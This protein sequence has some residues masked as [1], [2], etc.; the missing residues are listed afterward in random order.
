MPGHSSPHETEWSL[1]LAACCDLPAETKAG[2]I[3]DLLASHIEWS[4]L[5]SLAENHGMMPL[6]AQALLSVEHEIP[7]EAI[8]SLKQ[9]YQANLHKAL[10][11]SREFVSIVE[12]L[13]QAGIEFLPYKGLA[14]AE[15][16]YGDIALRQTGD[17]DLLIHAADLKRVREAVAHLGYMPH[18]KLSAHEEEFYLRSGYEC[19]FDGPAGKNLLEVQWAIQPRFYAVDLGMEDLFH[20]AIKATVAGVDVKTLSPED[21]FV[22][23]ALHA[24]KHAWGKLIW[25]RD[26]SR[27]SRAPTLDWKSIA[28]RA[29]VLGIVRILWVTLLLA[30]KLFNSPVPASAREDLPE[31]AAAETL[32]EEIKSYV[33]SERIFDVESSTYFKLMIRLRERKSDRIRFLSRLAFTPGPGEWAVARFPKALFP[34]YRLIRITRLGSRIVSGRI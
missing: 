17:I 34:L 23:L 33:E 29:R 13:S 20:R 16:V 8:K 22:V 28:N 27:V 9:G 10:F 24:A 2:R 21:S 19:A 18:H 30:E 1:L 6:L 12:C 14:L 5:H 11:L 31:D 25:I 4:A 7:A 32:A 3:R 26:L 15:G